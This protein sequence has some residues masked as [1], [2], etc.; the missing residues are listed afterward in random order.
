LIPVTL[1]DKKTKKNKKTYLQPLRPERT[2]EHNLGDG[3]DAF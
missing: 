2:P 3:W 1:H